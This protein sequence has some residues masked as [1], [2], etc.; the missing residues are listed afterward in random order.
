MDA[1]NSRKPLT[2][3]SPNSASETSPHRQ[4][5]Y[6][7]RMQ[8]LIAII[9]VGV[10]VALAATYGFSYQSARGLTV[11]IA[12]ISRTYNPSAYGAS[13][14]FDVEAHVWSTNSLDT[15]I[16]QVQFGF[17]ADN[18]PF[19]TESAR[20]STFSPHSFLQYNLRFIDSNSQEAT[21]LVDRTSNRISL[22]ISTFVVAGFYSGSVSPSS[23]R[24]VTH[25]RFADAT[26]NP[27]VLNDCQSVSKQVALQ[28][29][30]GVTI[31]LSSSPDTVSISIT[32]SQGT[33]VF[34]QESTNIDST[35]RL[36]A[37]TYT[38]QVT[39]PGFFC[40]GSPDQIS[41]SV[42]VW[43]EVANLENPVYS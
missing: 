25:S 11:E 32:D 41:G 12:Q 38:V 18:I 43:H 6:W 2:G 1:R 9:L 15:S 13:I 34:N 20:G 37:G 23:S 16:D 29:G 36:A 35:M 22:S 28:Q 7:Q 10:I 5:R 26:I 31:Q 4:R 30:G 39:N 8:V 17:S 27:T 40:S 42:T 33:S 24:I 3:Q 21:T 19:Q 14:E